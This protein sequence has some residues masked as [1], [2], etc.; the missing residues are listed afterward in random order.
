MIFKN[1]FAAFKYF[2][3]ALHNKEFKDC[4]FS[5]DLLL[6]QY[7]HTGYKEYRQLY[8]VGITEESLILAHKQLQNKPYIDPEMMLQLV[9]KKNE[10]EELLYLIKNKNMLN[11]IH[12]Y[13]IK[14]FPFATKQD[15][16][17]IFTQLKDQLFKTNLLDLIKHKEKNIVAT[18][19][20]YYIN[21]FENDVFKI[22]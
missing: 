17:F 14:Y 10:E 4:K 16:W 15:A 19:K 9:Q 20:I 11:D 1:P 21:L 5:L 7:I 8:K 13:V 12:E 6:L 18:N 22:E 2:C 3:Q